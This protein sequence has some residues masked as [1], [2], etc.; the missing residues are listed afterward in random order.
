MFFTYVYRELRRRHRQALLT[1]LGLALGVGLVVAVTAATRGVHT[2]QDEVLHSLYGVGTD[3]TV[4]QTAAFGS[5]GPQRFGMDPGDDQQGEEFS[6]D[7]VMST[8]G[9]ATLPADKTAQIAALDGV[10]ASASGLS[11]T[12]IHIEGKFPKGTIPGQGAPTGAVMPGADGQQTQTG[13]QPDVNMAPIKVTTYSLMGVDTTVSGVGPL[14]ADQITSGRFFTSADEKAYV[15]VLDA[16]YAKQN[17]LAVGDTTKIDGKK[18]D[19]IGIAATPGGG[20]TTNIYLPLTRAQ[21]LAGDSA[22]VNQIYVRASSADQISAVKSEI[23]SAMPKASVTTAEDLA[24]QVSGSLSSA[25]KLADRLGKWVAGAAL[26]AA[27]AL[28]SLLTLSSVGRRVR[29]FGT[30]KAIGWRS[31]R[32]VGQVLG[33]ATMIGVIGGAI[34]IGIGLLGA[35]LIARLSPSLEATVGAFGADNAGLP[36]M[37]GSM[38]QEA[39]VS[40]TNTITVPLTAPV[41]LQLIGL[42]IALALAGALI[43]GGLGGWRAARLRP[44]DALRRVD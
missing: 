22:A 30:L 34:G 7:R 43:A 35:Q 15:V 32:I 38:A 11:L 8:P 28:A 12:A 9:L 3:I 29:E 1:A 5:G 10:A 23:S 25:S 20:S 33:E 16:G 14:G 37:A 24:S 39:G 17:K 41:S 13:Q 2:A 31:R 6:R 21:A 44:A 18:Y 27:F 36:P 4:T 42:A 26:I 40:L 19:V